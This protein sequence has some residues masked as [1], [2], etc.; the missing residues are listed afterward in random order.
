[1][2]FFLQKS[3]LVHLADHRN[4]RSNAYKMKA[5]RKK[6]GSITSFA[7]FGLLE[8]FIR[9]AHV[10][11]IVERPQRW[12]LGTSACVL[13]ESDAKEAEFVFDTRSACG[14]NRN[15]HSHTHTHECEHTVTQFPLFDWQEARHPPTLTDF[16]I[17]FDSMVKAEFIRN[18]Q[19]VCPCSCVCVWQRPI[20]LPLW[21]Q[22]SQILSQPPW[23]HCS[24]HGSNMS[25][26]SSCFTHVKLEVFIQKSGNGHRLPTDL[27]ARRGAN[28]PRGWQ[29]RKIVF[30]TPHTNTLVFSWGSILTGQVEWS[31]IHVFKYIKVPLNVK[32]TKK[33]FILKA[34]HYVWLE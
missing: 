1:M 26:A 2:A 27:S 23:T 12:T 34:G 28:M 19:R 7:Y 6:K 25:E 21:Y 4:I 11:S 8:V 18:P 32:Q 17:L 30:K 10:H 33:I 31:V 3:E 5:N 14:G 29:T 13:K 22:S 16:I 15:T 24:A 20:R 9:S